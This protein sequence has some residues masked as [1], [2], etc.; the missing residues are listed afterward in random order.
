MT[1][2]PQAVNCF[3]L[4]FLQGCILARRGYA[5]AKKNNLKLSVETYF[6]RG[7]NAYSTQ[8][9]KAIFHFATNTAFLKARP[10]NMNR[11]R[12]PRQTRQLLAAQCPYVSSTFPCVL[13]SRPG[14]HG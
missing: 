3:T 10:A 14:V 5:S 11:P 6:R 12:P 4:F 13:Q 1:V 8:L 9:W 2:W 7:R